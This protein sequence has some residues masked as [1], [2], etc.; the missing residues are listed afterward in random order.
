[1]P[2]LPL[3]GKAL[4]QPKPHQFIVPNRRNAREHES[5]RQRLLSALICTVHTMVT[6]PRHRPSYEPKETPPFLVVKEPSPYF[7]ATLFH[8][9]NGFSC[10][11][12]VHSN[13]SDLKSLL[14]SDLLPPCTN[15]L[16]RK[17]EM[18]LWLHFWRVLRVWRCCYWTDKK[19]LRVPFSHCRDFTLNMIGQ[20]QLMNAPVPLIGEPDYSLKTSFFF[21]YGQYMCYITIQY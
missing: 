20:P 11:S 4:L 10:H 8:L 16:T 19:S 18:K 17:R 1:M 7:A 13:A 2:H 3:W 12:G 6:P 21:G 9:L 5:G 15:Y 14:R